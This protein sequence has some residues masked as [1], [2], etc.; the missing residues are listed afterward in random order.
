MT[1]LSSFVWMWVQNNTP[2]QF[3]SMPDTELE[4]GQHW[5]YPVLVSDADPGTAL[6]ISTIQL[7]PGM[8]WNESISSLNWTAPD[9]VG[10]Y[11]VILEV[12][13]GVTTTSC[14]GQFAVD[15]RPSCAII[16]P[17]AAATVGDITIVI[18]E[19]LDPDDILVTVLVLYSTNMGV[20]FTAATPDSV[21]P[22]CT[23]ST[24]TS[25]VAC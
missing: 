20:S 19:A 1:V 24:S 9:M 15:N 8:E 18:Y 5:I 2:P 23:K 22:D 7:Q 11:P 16:A 17:T 13:D 6:T 3:D 14:S 21:A 10:T 25:I 12:D 4:P